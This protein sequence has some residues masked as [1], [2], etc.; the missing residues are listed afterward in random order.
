MFR[1]AL[2]IASIAFMSPAAANDAP[3]KPLTN[4]DA[5]SLISALRALDGHQQVVKL[6]GQDAVVIVPWEFKSAAL[7]IKL[8]RDLDKLAPIE[9]SVN[10]GQNGIV[11]EL[12]KTIPDN[13]DGIKPSSINQSMPQWVDYEKQYNE[14]LN[15]PALIDGDLF[16]FKASELKLDVNEI[17][18]STLAGLHPIMD[19]DVSH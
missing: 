19:D 9:H 6:N 17:P 4:A 8:S 7:R 5:I 10:E 12:L 14:M 3:V 16:H 11:R 18:G 15:A 13:K 1:T 2:A